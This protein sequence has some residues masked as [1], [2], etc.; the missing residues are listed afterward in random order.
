MVYPASHKVSRVSWYSGTVS[1]VAYLFDYGAVTLYG[2]SFQ[3]PLSKVVI[4]NSLTLLPR[5][6]NVPQPPAGNACRL[7]TYEVWAL[8]CSLAATYGVA[9]AFLSSGY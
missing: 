1:G 5:V 3:R 9:V 6:R 2:G 4:C 7:D 8:P